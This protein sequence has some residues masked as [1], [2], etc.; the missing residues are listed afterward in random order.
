MDCER[1]SLESSSEQKRRAEEMPVVLSNTHTEGGAD[2]SLLRLAV[3]TRLRAPTHSLS[4]QSHVSGSLGA[5]LALCAVG[6]G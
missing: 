1:C 3:G 2:L 6:E 4:L 5:E